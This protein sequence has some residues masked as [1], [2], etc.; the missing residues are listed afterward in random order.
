MQLTNAA[1][2]LPF[3]GLLK[4]EF[5]STAI[6]ATLNTTIE[7]IKD[8]AAL[9]ALTLFDP[10]NRDLHFGDDKTFGS[11]FS[12]NKYG[13]GFTKGLSILWAYLICLDETENELR[14]PD[15]LQFAEKVRQVG[16]D[17]LLRLKSGE[18]TLSDVRRQAEQI[19]NFGG[20]YNT[21]CLQADSVKNIVPEGV[22]NVAVEID[23]YSGHLVAKLPEDFSSQLLTSYRSEIESHLTE[24]GKKSLNLPYNTGFVVIAY[25]DELAKISQEQVDQL[26]SKRVDLS[27][28]KPYAVP[29]RGDNR[30][31]LVASIIMD[32]KDITTIRESIGLKT[33]YS[34]GRPLRFTFAAVRNPHLP[35]DE[36]TLLKRVQ[37]SKFL[38][39]W[40]LF[41]SSI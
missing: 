32:S 14:S 22:I 11:L 35:V 34:E 13:A 40:M 7:A 15:V 26:L 6:P 3:A 29:V 10:N 8:K 28:N 30:Y 20:Y 1:D 24:E 38:K 27:F 39:D 2:V 33:L 5:V 23:A 31:A 19:D 36:N 9:L 41:A 21:V 12:Q 17:T 16:T 18:K 4:Y 37:N 25:K